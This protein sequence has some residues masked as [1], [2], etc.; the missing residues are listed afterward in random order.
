[1]HDLNTFRNHLEEIRDRLATRG[2][3]LD[4]AAFEE[5]DARRRQLLTES[6]QIKAERNHASAEIGKLRKS[7]EDTT[8]RQEHVRALG[9]RIAE[10]DAEVVNLETAFRDFLARVPNLP[11][12]DVPVGMNESQNREVKRWGAPPQFSFQ[13]KPHWDLGA[14]L[15][16]LDL[17]R[18]AKVTGARFAVYWGLG[19]RLERALINFM[20]DL[21]TREHGYLEVLPPFLI[22]SASLYGTG[23]LPKFAEDLFRCEGR[24]LWLAP[25]AEV[26]VTN[27]F[28]DETLNTESLPISLCAY[29]PCFRSEAGSYGRDVRGIIRQHQFQKVELVK[30][31]RADQSAEEH[32]KLTHHAETILERLG[33]PYRTVVLC[34][35]DMGFSAAKTYD[36]EVWLPGQ[37]A[38]KEISSCSNFD[39]FQARRAQIRHKGGKGKAEFVHT[40]NGSGLAAG[41]T[42][43]AIVENYQQSDGSILI[44]DALRPYLNAERIDACGG[45]RLR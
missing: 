39:A 32:E 27:L 30:F 28:R 22:N 8:Q 13:P 34:T 5:L 37:N 38:Y 9:T 19:A 24:D 42:W 17:E 14:D 7:G 33:L 15:Q 1:M 25:T 40:L 6:E 18:A 26:P 12:A 16:I 29:T 45:L 20:L 2:Y 44:P 41:R 36:I 43:V 23:N 3:Q 10:L 31:T 4:V 21:H 11:Y 35:G